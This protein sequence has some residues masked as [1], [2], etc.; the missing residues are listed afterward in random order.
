M[1]QS[2]HR[3]LLLPAFETGLK[4]RKSL[5][6]WRDLE[7]TQWLSR[8]EVEQVQFEALSRLIRHAFDN[9][10]Y[11]RGAWLKG[12]LHPQQ[13]RSLADFTRWPLITR[14]T[15][16]AHRMDMRAT[17]PRLRLMSKATGGSSGVPLQFDLDFGSFD[18]RTAAW[19]R[20]YEWA[21]AGPGTKQLYL[22]GVPLG[23]RSRTS[24]LK[25]HLYNRFHRRLVLNSFE[26]SEATADAFLQRLNRYR[27]EVI[28]AYTNPLYAFARILKDRGVRPSSPKSIVV[29]AEKLH[30]FQ[31]ELIEDVF[32]APVFETYGSREFMLMGAECDRHQGLH[33]T[34]ENLLIEVLNER[35]ERAADGQEGD[36]VVTDLYNYGMPFIRYANGDRAIAGGGTCSCGRGLPLLKKVV[37]RQLDLIITPDGR[38]VPGEFF[39]HLMKD[40]D[41]VRQFQVVQDA[42]DHVKLVVV[43]KGE[44]DAR[45]RSLLECQVHD[46]LGDATRFEIEPVD[47][48]PLTSAGKLR[49]VVNLVSPDQV[50]PGGDD[51]SRGAVDKNV[52]RPCATVQM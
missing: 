20:G 33:M 49:V 14:D 21:G 51:A 50:F 15:I 40:H 3:R 16:R 43:I 32:N 22:W 47:E 5:R 44:W 46:V 6:Y 8:A 1:M 12:G 9:C 27:P 11:Y 17:H 38:R 30:S 36:V 10:P 25:D 18:R 45:S 4:R 34:M 41:A 28:V 23:A 24:R 13:L 29:G 19:H 7:R 42:L 31:R 26:L 37:G 39:P 35:G 48:I 52:A 2:V